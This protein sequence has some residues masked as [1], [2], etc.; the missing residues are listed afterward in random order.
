MAETGAPGLT[1]SLVATRRGCCALDYIGFARLEGRG[2]RVTNDTLFEIGSI[3]KSFV[4]VAL[5]QL[6]HEGKLDFSRPSPT[7][8]RGSRFETQL[9]RHRQPPRHAHGGAARRAAPPGRPARAAVDGLQAGRALP[10]LEH[11]LQRPRL[12]HRGRGRSALRR[13]DARPRP[14]AARHDRELPHDHERDARADGRR[15]RTRPRRQAVAHAQ[16]FGR[17]AG[18]EVDTRRQ[19]PRRKPTASYCAR[20][21]RGQLTETAD[22]S[23]R[24]VQLMNLARI[25][26]LRGRRRLTLRPWSERHHRAH[27]PVAHGGWS[28][29]SS[30][31]TLTG[32][33]KVGRVRSSQ[34]EPARIPAVAVTEVSNRRPSTRRS[35]G[36]LCQRPAP[37][38]ARRGQKDR[39]SSPELTRGDGRKSRSSR[40]AE[41]GGCCTRAAASVRARARCP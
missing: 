31:S 41:T 37:R 15:L 32:R 12:R 35:R 22:S 14:R 24:R 25:G 3:S 13:G 36:R 6:A 17:G 19:S 16:A 10:L 2:A 20:S 1:L 40:G 38:R 39:P 29:F 21:H 27:A 9:N 7:T 5:L 33:A 26:R 30:S 4:A 11:R 34:R 8:S 28:H 23:P 18:V